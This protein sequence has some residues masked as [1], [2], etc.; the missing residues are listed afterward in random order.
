MQ[1]FEF[2]RGKICMTVYKTNKGVVLRISH[3]LRTQIPGDHY[4]DPDNME[5]DGVDL[6]FTRK[7]D[8]RQLKEIIKEV[9]KA[10][11]NDTM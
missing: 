11:T 9:S 10:L 4:I 3:L 2:G 8:L 5:L 1:R 7:K 6:I